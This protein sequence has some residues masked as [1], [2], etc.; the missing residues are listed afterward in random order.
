MNQLLFDVLGIFTFLAL[1][2]VNA[3]SFK[4]QTHSG[5]YELG[6]FLLSLL[7]KAGR[8]SVVFVEILW[9]QKDLA[10]NLSLPWVILGLSLGFLGPHIPHLCKEDYNI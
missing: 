10:L 3:V 5:F 8:F 4:L 9:N 6:I 7:Q 1:N 2:P